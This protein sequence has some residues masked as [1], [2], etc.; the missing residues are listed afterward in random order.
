MMWLGNKLYKL[1]N[2]YTTTLE[3]SYKN[4]LEKYMASFN[5]WNL[6]DSERTYKGANAWYIIE[7]YSL[8]NCIC[9]IINEYNRNLS[10]KRRKR[11]LKDFLSNKINILICMDFIARGLDMMNLNYVVNFD[12]PMHYNVLT[13]RVGRFSKYINRKGTVYYFIKRSE[14]RIMMKSG[15]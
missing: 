11:I 8:L 2:N 10:H 6:I 15:K 9:K 7:L 4:H 12:I 1:E 14:K 13:H 5:Y 3:E